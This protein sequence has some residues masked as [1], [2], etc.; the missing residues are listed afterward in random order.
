MGDTTRRSFFKRAAVTVFSATVLGA[1]A[2]LFGEE[3]VIKTRLK[4]LV[5]LINTEGQ[6][7]DTPG[8]QP[9]KVLTRDVGG[10]LTYVMSLDDDRIAIDGHRKEKKDGSV[11]VLYINDFGIDG[12]PELSR[13]STDDLIISLGVNSPSPHQ[14]LK[15]HGFEGIASID[16]DGMISLIHT[17]G[18]RSKNAY[19]TKDREFGER[20]YT[21]II[22]SI[23]SAPKKR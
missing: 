21:A 12:F 1:M 10:D 7:S 6:E 3:R 20:I 11:F 5:D 8:R 15:D 2:N 14:W 22:D 13:Y 18:R 17:Y 23:L 19:D 9:S 16:E 4:T